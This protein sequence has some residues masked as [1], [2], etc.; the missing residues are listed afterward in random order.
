MA[1]FMEKTDIMYYN[2]KYIKTQRQ[3]PVLSIEII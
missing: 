1:L 2:K 3:I